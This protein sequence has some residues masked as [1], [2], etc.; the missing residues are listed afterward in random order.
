MELV[1]LNGAK[2]GTIFSSPLSAGNHVF[3]WN[4][5]T[6]KNGMV[7]TGMAL[8]RLSSITGCITK[9]VVIGR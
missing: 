5:K 4:G 3:Q 1:G 9:P 8:L 6:I 2:I 7:A